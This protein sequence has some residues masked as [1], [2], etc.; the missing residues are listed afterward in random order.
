MTEGETS[1]GPRLPALPD[2]RLDGE[3]RRVKAAIV[4]GPRGAMLGPYDAW[5]RRPQLAERARAVGDYVRFE[6]TL[7]RDLAEL[8]ILTTA[9]RWKA[10]FEFYA[11]APFARD[12]G[13]PDDVIEAIR[14]GG[15]PPFA[16]ER[17]RVVHEL[18][19][20]YFRT[21]RVSG[22]TYARALDL[23]GEEHLVDLV[24]VVGYYALVSMTLNVFEVPVPPGVEEPLAGEWT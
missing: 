19:T 3:Q 10:Q 16:D 13:V 1:T 7:P 11:H 12:A 24:G 5:L 20:E 23:L 9:R 14:T 17:H 21:N 18:V 2:D 22:A 8:A 6:S 4:G 15:E